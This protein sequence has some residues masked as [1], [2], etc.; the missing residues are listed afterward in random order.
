MNKLSLI[1]VI[2]SLALAAPALAQSPSDIRNGRTGAASN[3]SSEVNIDHADKG[4]DTANTG[5]HHGKKHSA[6]KH[7]GKKHPAKKHH[8]KKPHHRAEVKTDAT[9]PAAEGNTGK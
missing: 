6:K 4:G 7:H 3:D 1:A 2:A 8:A 9:A 5:K